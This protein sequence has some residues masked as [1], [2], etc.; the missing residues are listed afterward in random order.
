MRIIHS[1]KTNDNDVD[2]IT[3]I[4]VTTGHTR[5][6]LIGLAG[7]VVLNY[8]VTGPCKLLS[9]TAV[10]VYV[11]DSGNNETNN[12]SG[13]ITVNKSGNDQAGVY[14][15]ITDET[16]TGY[17]IVDQETSEVQTFSSAGSTGQTSLGSAFIGVAFKLTHAAANNLAVD[18]DYA[19]AADFCN[20]DQN[21]G[22][23]THNCIYRLEAEE[24]GANTGIFEG[25]VEYINLVNST[26]ANGGHAG[27]G[28]GVASKLGYVNGDA[29]TVVLMD[30]TSGSDSV[31]VV[32]NDT[33]AFQVATKIGA[34]LETS[35]HTG[36]I[37]LDADT[38]GVSDIGTITIVDADLNQDSSIR[39]TYTNLS[40]IHI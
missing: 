9:C 36:T 10:S 37:D 27:N 33:D 1:A 23:L 6:T 34:Q 5:S 38:Y 12:I 18:A 28:L 14:D 29:L 7:T 8:D 17:F 2:L 40:L 25:T 26:S 11:V 4:N 39:D 21:N 3:W 31:R 24:T 13:S 16:G 35:V 22:S 20:F 32:Y 15:L 19:I 30:A